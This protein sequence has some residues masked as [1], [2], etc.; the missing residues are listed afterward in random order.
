MA[1]KDINCDEYSNSRKIY[2]AMLEIRRDLCR[3][4][5]MKEK[6]GYRQDILTENLNE[7]EKAILICKNCQGIMK[8]A[9][10]TEIGEQLCSSCCGRGKKTP[11]LP[12]RKMIDSLKCCCPLIERGCKWLGTL[13]CCENHLD[14]CG[15]VSETC[16]LNCGE[17]LSREE[18]ERHEKENCKQRQVKCDHCNERI[19]SRELDGHLEKCRKMK[20]SCHLCD[21]RIP[22]EEMELHSRCVCGMV[23]EKCTLGCGMEL[24]RNKL[25]IHE[26]DNCV[27][28]IIR[29]EHCCI[30]VKFCDNSKHLKECPL[31]KVTCYQCGVAKYR[32]DMTQHFKDD[33][34]EKMIDCPFVKYK[35]LARMK[36]KDIDKHLE[37][38]ETKHLELKLT[39]MEDF[40]IKQNE[41]FT[42][43]SEEVNN[44]NKI[45]TKQSEELK[46]LNEDIE[47]QKKEII[48]Q[49]EGMTREISNTSKQIQLMYFITDTTRIIWKI[50]DV[51]YS[52]D[53]SSISKQY[54]VA[55][56]SFALKLQYY[57]RLIIVFPGTTIKPDRPF[58]AKYHIMVHPCHTI[59]CGTIE[60]KQKNVTRGYKG[61]ITFISQE[62][63]EKYSIPEFPG[64]TKKDL[65]LEIFITVY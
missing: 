52:I 18:L 38:K 3:I 45:I 12:V 60:V 59:N 31:V 51:K 61:L 28:Q 4:K 62:D 63:I 57:G 44:K 14:T 65:T 19:I 10:I 42:K 26:K 9:C 23:K 17:V 7:R 58:I 5:R 46:K 50:E 22:R 55:G 2:S 56:L 47:E 1:G 29:C 43:Q 32:K 21:I 37:E 49:S 36:R 15:Y 24:A 33:C 40:I 11:N 39:A 25:G 16:R 6:Y 8:E 48:K 30:E 34:S 27:Q 64:D 54:K 53:Y 35:C 41:E 20:V 13:E